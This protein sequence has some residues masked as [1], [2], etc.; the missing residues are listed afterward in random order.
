MAK[1]KT[2]SKNKASKTKNS[3]QRNSSGGGA[4]RI[5]GLLLLLLVLGGGAFVY[6]NPHI[7]DDVKVMA[8]LAEPAPTAP[9]PTTQGSAAIPVSSVQADPQAAEAL[10]MAKVW[11]DARLAKGSQLVEISETLQLSAAEKQHWQSISISQG[12]ISAVHV[13]GQA[14]H[15]M[16]LL[17]MQNGDQITWVCAGDVPAALEGMCSKS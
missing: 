1:L 17:P 16:I 9:A 3:R 13:N 8:G 4:G 2:N 14:D 12:T 15:P 6:L 10:N 11:V 7:I 5:V